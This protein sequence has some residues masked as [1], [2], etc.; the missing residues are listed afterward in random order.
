MSGQLPFAVMLGVLVWSGCSHGPAVAA[1]GWHQ[2][3][4]SSE[5][6]GPATSVSMIE[7]TAAR[8]TSLLTHHRAR[9]GP[10]LV[11]PISQSPL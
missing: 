4:H 2:S 9:H 1:S 5:A 10:A 6:L 7:R 8:N 11:E 3:A